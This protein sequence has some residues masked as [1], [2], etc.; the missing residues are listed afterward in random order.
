M[1]R[2]TA[3][4]VL[5]LLLQSSTAMGDG[6]A[7]DHS[8]LLEDVSVRAGVTA[9]ISVSVFVDEKD[10]RCRRARGARSSV[11][12][13][14]GIGFAA[15]SWRRMA[16]AVFD[17]QR[18]SGKRYCRWYAIDLPGQGASGLP[19][20]M[21]FG[22]LTLSDL[23]SAYRNTWQRLHAMRVRPH[24]VVGHSRGALLTQM[25]QHQLVQ[26]GS[27]LERE[28]GAEDALLL[29]ASP[30]ASVEWSA[31]TAELFALISSFVTF[32][33]ER[34]VFAEAPPEVWAFVSYSNLDGVPHPD[35]P[36]ADLA[37]YTAPEALAPVLETFG[38]APFSRPEVARGVFAP[39]RGTRLTMLAFTQDRFGLLPEQRALY[40]H[41]TRDASLSG[42]V[43]VDDEFA[44]H[45]LHDV[46]PELILQALDAHAAGKP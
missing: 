11:L 14:A 15:Q 10:P 4:A 16:D 29:G 22:E 17:T 25:L 44:V 24:T 41:L 8:I 35:T 42:L 45:N 2:M 1:K 43:V 28:F 20:G 12:A 33:P 40:E 13:L 39:R 7:S 34:G 36:L 27:S 6:G 18:K 21:L 30:P 37:T 46:K 26:E 23:L 31:A 38:F 5:G 19:A 32:T 9:D 3:G